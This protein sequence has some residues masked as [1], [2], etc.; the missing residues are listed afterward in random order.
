MKKILLNL[1]RSFSSKNNSIILHKA[2]GSVKQ[3]RY[4]SGLN[5]HFK[6]KN[7]CVEIYEPYNFVKKFRKASKIRIDG[8]NN[9]IIIKNTNSSIYSMKII[10]IKNNNKIVIGENFYQTGLLKIDF[11]N[12]SNMELIIG[13][14]CMFGQN[15]EIMLGDFHKVIDTLTNLQTNTPQKGVCIGNNVW[16]AR[17]VKILKDVSLPDSSIVG[18][19]S[20]VTKSFSQN[21][22]CIAG[23]PAKVVKTNVRWEK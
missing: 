2:N 19:G 10:G 20:I 18:T 14:D 5:I 6:G 11:C 22:V 1:L 23:I 21:N 3:V 7:S 4:I 17:D 16:L 8:D 9:H 13:K 12:L 15:I